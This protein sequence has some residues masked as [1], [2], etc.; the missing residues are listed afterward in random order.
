MTYVLFYSNYCK[1]SHKFIDILEKSGEA[2][3]FAKICVDKDQNGQRSN[4]ISKY[5]I[6]EVPTV[7]IENRQLAGYNAFIWL[8]NRIDNSQ[9][10]I[11]TLSTRQNKQ[12][13]SM[14]QLNQ[15][16]NIP[17]EL[18]GFSS[19]C[20]NSNFSD[21]HLQISN[22]ENSSSILTPKDTD[23]IEQARRGNFIIPSANISTPS[24]DYQQNQQQNQQPQGYGLS[25]PTISIS[26]DN[27]KKKQFDNEFN[28]MKS[29]RDSVGNKPIQR[30]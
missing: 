26:K 9:D 23:D 20:F 30:I 12:Q 1:F 7:L 8:K 13:V 3:Y 19:N 17:T 22:I 25:L 11:N 24:Q 16:K 4:I 2:T 29:E 27:L 15:T 6:T 10:Q 5:G 28:R 18:E 21:S 14:Q